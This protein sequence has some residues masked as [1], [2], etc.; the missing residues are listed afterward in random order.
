MMKTRRRMYAA[1]VVALW[2]GLVN[3]GAAQIKQLTPEKVLATLKPGQWVQLEGYTQRSFTVECS[4]VQILTGDFLDDDW[5]L[6]GVVRTIDKMQREAKILTVPVKFDKDTE[7]ENNTGKFGGF[8]D[9][10]IGMLVELEGTYLKDGTFLA[11]EVEDE[12]AKLAKKPKLKDEIQAMGKVEKVDAVKR[13]ITLMG[14]VFQL[15]DKT[16]CKSAIK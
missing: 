16:E 3:P 5:G 14:M 10:K 1:V 6:T 2:F 15:S 11:K 12:S 8:V 4:E 9:L 13:T 7:F